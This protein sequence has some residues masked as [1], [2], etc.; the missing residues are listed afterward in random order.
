M[1]QDEYFSVHAHLKI[2]VDVLPD[3][4]HIPSEAEFGREIPLAFRIASECGDL[5]SSVEKEIQALQHDEGH[6]LTKFLHAQNQKINLLLGF[7]LS[8]Q[9]DPNLRYQTETFGASS[10]TFIA[11]KAFKKGQ[12]VRLKLFLEN[13]P[14][15]IYCYGS[16]Y[17]CKEKNGKF[18]VGVKY[19]R[20]QEE[21]RDVLIR[22]ALHQQQKLLRQRALERNS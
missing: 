2:N 5:D 11:R 6:A 20:L 19:I 21:D 4:E 10:L 22:A 8:Q 1:S 13:P 7:M 18:A 12:H 9:D 16:V 17:G 3:D 15:A 14:S